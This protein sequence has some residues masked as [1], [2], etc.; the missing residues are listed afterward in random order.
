VQG[1][2]PGLRLHAIHSAGASGTVRLPAA[3]ATVAQS[4][5]ITRP[6]WGADESWRTFAPGCTGAASYAKNVSFL[7]V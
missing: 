4:G 7:I 6:Q 1:H 3:G 2:L 5:I